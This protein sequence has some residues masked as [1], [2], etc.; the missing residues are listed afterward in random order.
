MQ[1]TRNTRSRGALVLGIVLTVLILGLVTFV[2]LVFAFFFPWRT[3][4]QAATLQPVVQH[5]ATASEVEARYGIQVLM[6]GVTAEGGLIDLRYRVTDPAKANVLLDIDHRPQLI[7]EDSGAVLTRHI[8]PEV[9][10]LETGRVYFFLFANTRN[11]IRPG[12]QVSVVLEDL[13]LEHLVAQ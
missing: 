6:L 3:E 4:Q 1:D 7:A 2:V 11:A 5:T 8:R 13:R 10:E 9:K 12:S